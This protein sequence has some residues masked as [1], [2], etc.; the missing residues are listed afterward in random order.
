MTTP[1]TEINYLY[2]QSGNN[3]TITFKSNGNG[4]FT[5]NIFWF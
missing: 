2:V 1:F 4:T 3:Y 5:S